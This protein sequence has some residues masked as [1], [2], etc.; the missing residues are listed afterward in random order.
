[1]T[2]TLVRVDQKLIHGQIAVAWV[3]YLKV[4][5]ILVADDE[6]AQDEWAQAGMRL[7]LPPEITSVIFIAPA[8]VVQALKN[9]SSRRAMILFKDINSVLTALKAG[10]NLDQLN[11]GNQVYQPQIKTAQLTDTFHINREDYNALVNIHD[12]GIEITAQP[13]PRVKAVNWECLHINAF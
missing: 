2:L 4:D 9:C 5:T 12:Q 3:P 1:M 7:G 11:L 8:E 6:L 13:I 10:L